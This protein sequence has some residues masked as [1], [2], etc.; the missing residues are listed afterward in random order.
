M[1]ESEREAIS[2]A[3]TVSKTF[4]QVVENAS[5]MA[6]P[7]A[8]RPVLSGRYDEPTKSRDSATNGAL[9]A[10]DGSGTGAAREAG[11]PMDEASARYE[12]I[13]VLGEGGMGRVIAARDAQFGR[14]V[15][16]KEMTLGGDNPDFIRRFLLESIVTANLEHPGVVPVYERGVR[17]G[18]P[19]Y[20]MR[21][22]AGKTLTKA[23]QE[24]RDLEARLALIP[25]VI[26]AAHAL[27]FA[28]ARGVVHRDI[29]P[30][31]IILGDHGET[32]ILDWGIAKVRGLA[33]E[34]GPNSPLANV[35]E[36]AK[37][38]VA[39]SVLG[40]PSYMAPEQANGQID[41]IDARSD[42]F[43]LG[44]VLYE[45]L[46]GRP[47]YAE[48]SVVMTLAKASAAKFEPLEKVAPKVPAG[49]K[50]IVAKALNA[51]PA[52]RFIDGSELAKTLEQ[53]QSRAWLGEESFGAK[54]LARVTG[55]AGLLVLAV[56]S[57]AVWR[58]L[59]SLREMGVGS[60]FFV[61]TFIAS[62][63]L[64]LLEWWTKGRYRVLGLA[65]A[66]A[67]A[68]FLLGVTNAVGG[69]V[70]TFGALSAP[71][72]AADEAR[73][74]TVFSSGIYESIGNIAGSAVFAAL[75]AMMIALVHRSHTMRAN[76]VRQ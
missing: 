45:V 17:D 20:A 44:A 3:K 2:W 1:N 26:R 32:V 9:D 57:V 37:G 63:D 59:P 42:V 68:T 60:L 58:T 25:A 50:W 40:T 67:I 21:K 34:H 31:N 24:A 36:N 35:T 11:A 65:S 69:L 76:E 4:A 19:Y 16:L 43:A 62:F 38:T 27:G 10:D 28:H 51:E 41:A 12:P 61:F 70:Q 15:A 54:W 22:V 29:K 13:G 49:L 56:S 53:F 72:L 66:L 73:W 74:R 23:I 64:A 71:A 33:Q 47:P 18:A 55:I 14:T 52:E 75:A 30:D 5:T 48:I 6:A 8:V 46:A 7:S 39:G